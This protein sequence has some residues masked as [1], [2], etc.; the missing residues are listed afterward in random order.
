MGGY[1][2]PSPHSLLPLCRRSSLPSSHR[3]APPLTAAPRH[4]RVGSRRSAAGSSLL[5]PWLLLSS[6]GSPSPLSYCSLAASPAATR[7]AHRSRPRPRPPACRQLATLLRAASS[8]RSR[9]HR[10]QHRR[11]ADRGLGR[12]TPKQCT[13]E[14]APFC[15]GHT[16]DPFGAGTSEGEWGDKLVSE[17]GLIEAWLQSCLYVV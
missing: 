11:L 13:I 6:L 9:V 8:H 3:Q 7:C 14:L 10:L 1:P 2:G 16:S 15:E 4:L 5:S 12:P 17:S